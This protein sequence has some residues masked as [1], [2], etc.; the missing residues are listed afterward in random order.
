MTEAPIQ[1]Q[2]GKTGVKMRYYRAVAPRFRYADNR[3]WIKHR[4]I[5]YWQYNSAEDDLN[6]IEE[7][8]E[9]WQSMQLIMPVGIGK[10]DDTGCLR[11][12]RF[13][14]NVSWMLLLRHEQTA[15]PESHKA[16]HQVSC[17]HKN[18]FRN[19]QQV[20]GKQH[21]LSMQYF[22]QNRAMGFM[23]L[24]ADDKAVNIQIRDLIEAGHRGHS[25]FLWKGKI[26]ELSD[27]KFIDLPCPVKEWEQ[28]I[29]IARQHLQDK[30]TALD[31]MRAHYTSLLAQ[32]AQV[33]HFTEMAQRFPQSKYRAGYQPD[34]VLGALR[35][36]VKQLDKHHHSQLQ[37]SKAIQAIVD[38]ATRL[39]ELLQSAAL[40]SQID[41]ELELSIQHLQHDEPT[42]IDWGEIRIYQ[43]LSESYEFILQLAAQNPKIKTLCKDLVSQQI[44]P[45]ITYLSDPS[46]QAA[47]QGLLASIARYCGLA[48]SLA[49]NFPGP[50]SFLVALINIYGYH[51]EHLSG[52]KTISPRFINKH[53]AICRNVLKAANFNQPLQPGSWDK[54]ERDI[55]SG[56]LNKIGKNFLK[57]G[58]SSINNADMLA[59]AAVYQNMMRLFLIISLAN[60]VTQQKQQQHDSAEFLRNLAG[61]VSLITD[62]TLSV[63]QYLPVIKRVSPYAIGVVG[64]IANSVILIIDLHNNKH[65]DNVETFLAVMQISV[66]LLIVFAQWL[67][68]AP[69]ITYL[70]AARTLLLAAQKIYEL[71]QSDG[72]K[73]VIQTLD[74]LDKSIQRLIPSTSSSK[75]A[76]TAI[77][78]ALKTVYQNCQLMDWD[79]LSWRAAIPLMESGFNVQYR[80]KQIDIKKT[81]ELLDTYIDMR[82]FPHELLPP[83]LRQK[84]DCEDSEQAL[85]ALI[86]HYQKLKTQYH[87][88]DLSNQHELF[89]W[90]QGTI[91]PRL[92][93][94]A[95]LEQSPDLDANINWSSGAH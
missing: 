84:W 71:T 53:L 43:I 11:H 94:L 2:F 72:K 37:D 3:E 20:G 36:L 83:L 69:V 62:I 93:P 23:L 33:K 52:V 25:Q 78:Q 55:K 70:I 6:R 19:L 27:K 10:T 51:I 15:H 29:I 85:A 49:A 45:V 35:E 34:R 81:A 21:Y 50:P 75:N 41:F 54:L 90:Q 17:S 61:A 42:L 77:D 32:V 86:E 73:F 76:H 13:V 67:A 79:N 24:P 7:F 26:A 28:R 30:I 60:F 16:L 95:V 92:Q 8:P 74:N 59:A 65:Q 40:Y 4:Y 14:D 38:A 87:T 46:Q 44:R 18:R 68:L 39:L 22:T 1:S 47:K 31:E 5:L 48:V 12:H 66:E 91:Q 82:D 64:A 63:H 80:W 58:L 56:H 9:Y 89:Q 88:G 57:T